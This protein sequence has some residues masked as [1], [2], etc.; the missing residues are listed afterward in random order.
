MIRIGIPVRSISG[1]YVV[2]QNYVEALKRANAEAFVILPST[3]LESIMPLLQ[4]ILI[5]GGGDVDPSLYN[6]EITLSDWIDPEIDR[7]DSSLIEVA[8]KHQLEI[9]GICR[10]LQIINVVLKGSLI[11]DIPSSIQT[12]IDHSYSEH[13]SAPTQGHLIKVKAGSRLS[14]LLPSEIIV[15][16]YHHQAIKKLAETCSVSALSEDGIIEAIE[17]PHLLAVQWHPERMIED[18]LVQG[19]FNDFIKRC[20]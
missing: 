19:L 6:E 11:Q 14:T 17:G 4:G 15:N 8:L 9:F 20:L 12:K 16:S 10:G 2:N 7:L 18:P 13:H 1:R 5:P 3:D